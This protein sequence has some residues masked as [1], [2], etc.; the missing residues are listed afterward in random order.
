MN[1]V[2]G[3]AAKPSFA[4]FFCLQMGSMRMRLDKKGRPFLRCG[5]CGVQVF[6]HESAS[7]RGLVLWDD[8]VRIFISKM[9]QADLA[10][11]EQRGVELVQNLA[12][13]ATAVG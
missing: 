10:Q 13:T 3:S 5:M 1:F 11:N 12:Q 7:L 2:G 8:A 6:I 9:Q 4:C